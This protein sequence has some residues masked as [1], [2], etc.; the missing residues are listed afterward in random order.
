MTR[1]GAGAV[2]QI[3]LRKLFR[4]A[5][6]LRRKRDERYVADRKGDRALGKDRRRPRSVRQRETR[7][8]VEINDA[9]R[10]AGRRRDGADQQMAER[11]RGIV[12]QPDVALRVPTRDDE[13]LRVR[14]QHGASVTRRTHPEKAMTGLPR[15]LVRLGAAK[16]SHERIR[17]MEVD[18]RASTEDGRGRVLGRGE[19][20][21]PR[22]A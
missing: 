14:E 1:D 8:A 16:L 19:R 9:E 17:R 11:D 4:K 20:V 5:V 7:V 21:Q 10:E 15:Q 6:V 18:R 22:S 13:R 2:V 12:E 3:R